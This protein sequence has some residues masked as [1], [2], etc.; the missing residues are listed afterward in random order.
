[1]KQDVLMISEQASADYELNLVSKIKEQV[2]LMVTNKT[3]Y[4]AQTNLMGLDLKFQVMKPGGVKDLMFNINQDRF[5]EA[6]AV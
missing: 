5:F 4:G 6:R 3:E 1:M 2:S